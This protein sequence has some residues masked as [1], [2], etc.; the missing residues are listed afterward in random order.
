M[1]ARLLWLCTRSMGAWVSRVWQL[2]ESCRISR[3][4]KAMKELK[5]FC[6]RPVI[7]ARIARIGDTSNYLRPP[8]RG[9]LFSRAE[10]QGV[11][12]MG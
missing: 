5:V 7:G 10:R 2:W 3:R 8:R 6:P 4:L 11:R 9:G 12:G 1:V